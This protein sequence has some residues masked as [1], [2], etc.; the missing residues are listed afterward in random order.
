MVVLSVKLAVDLNLKGEGEWSFCL[1][2]FLFFL[3]I[4]MIAVNL[5]VLR[6]FMA[7]QLRIFGSD[8]E[9]KSNSSL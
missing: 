6:G 2:F 7:K 5:M 1:F 3:K 4:K 9:N 8:G